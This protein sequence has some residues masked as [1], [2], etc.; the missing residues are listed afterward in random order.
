MLRR[1]GVMLAD[2][3]RRYQSYNPETGG[4][5]KPRLMTEYAEIIGINYVYLS[6]IYS[7]GRKPGMETFGKLMRAFPDAAPK[8]AA[9]MASAM[10]AADPAKV[11]P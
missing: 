6:Q 3:I 5:D 10:T 2:I 7:G 4:F 9:E 11:A 8:I 1:K